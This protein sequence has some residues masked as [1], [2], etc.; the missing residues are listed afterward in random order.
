MRRKNI[1]LLYQRGKCSLGSA[2]RD[3]HGNIDI[4]KN[5]RYKEKICEQFLKGLCLNGEVCIYIHPEESE[6]GAEKE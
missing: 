2:C 3:Y 4:K 5:Y 6:K 1:C